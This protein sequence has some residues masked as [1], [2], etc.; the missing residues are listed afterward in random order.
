MVDLG[1]IFQH[2]RCG[3]HYRYIAEYE[4]LHPE[5]LLLERA[6]RALGNPLHALNERIK[7]L[8]ANRARCPKERGIGQEVR[9]KRVPI[10]R[11]VSGPSQALEMSTDQRP[12]RWHVIALVN[13]RHSTASLRSSIRLKY[14]IQKAARA[15]NALFPRC[16]LT[17]ARRATPSFPQIS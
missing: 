12:D 16:Q 1:T 8:L 9:P 17:T 7:R 14:S 3:Q 15:Q 6:Q 10:R 4:N 13:S 5:R 2:P 11:C